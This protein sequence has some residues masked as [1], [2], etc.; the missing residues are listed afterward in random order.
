MQN[1]LML[2]LGILKL[3]HGCEGRL[4]PRHH[5][6]LTMTDKAVARAVT[7][8]L[9]ILAA[10]SLYSAYVLNEKLDLI[11]TKVR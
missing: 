10:I 6:I 1:G 11:E 2:G 3:K 5:R 9:V 7:A 8:L 4:N